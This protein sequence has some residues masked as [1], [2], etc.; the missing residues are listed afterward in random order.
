MLLLR[1]RYVIATFVVGV[2]AAGCGNVAKQTSIKAEEEYQGI[3]TDIRTDS[4]TEV[5]VELGDV[6]YSSIATKRLRL[7][8][9]TNTT[10]SLLD[11]KSTCRC[12]WISLP[13]EAIAPGEYGEL[14]L[15]FDSRGEFGS[16]GNYID[17]STS[18]ADCRIGVWMSAKVI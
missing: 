11:Y 6:A 4:I 15:T 2:I 16:V 14:E 13:N 7:K 9:T 10:L 1:L 3:T 12:T 8:N 18:D 17:I 5:L